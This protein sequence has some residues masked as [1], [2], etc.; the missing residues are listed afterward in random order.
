LF[1]YLS[2]GYIEELLE[3]DIGR[4]AIALALSAQVVGFLVI[5]KIVNI[6]I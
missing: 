2:P 4:Y 3:V 6:K 5:R 1:Y